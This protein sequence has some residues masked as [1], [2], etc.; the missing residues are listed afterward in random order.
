MIDEKTITK[1]DENWIGEQLDS[2]ASNPTPSN[3]R[4]ESELD[5]VE[6]KEHKLTTVETKV[7]MAG[8]IEI[9]GLED[10]PTS[11]LAVPYVKLVQG[12]SEAILADGKAEAAKGTFYFTDIKEAVE[13]LKFV[14]LRAKPVTKEFDDEDG[15]KKLVRQLMVLGATTDSKTPKIFVLILSLTSFTGFGKLVAMFKNMKVS[16]VWEYEVTGYATPR[17]NAKGS[18][19]VADFTI[20]KKLPESAIAKMR[21]A[22]G[23]YGGVLERNDIPVEES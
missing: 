14:L 3:D 18:F 7:S 12:N 22:Y 21:E 4:V 19:Y 23:E 13:E 10:V 1:D 8:G 17:K 6:E 5:Q 2:S 9:E 20:G 11:M 15:N 16:S